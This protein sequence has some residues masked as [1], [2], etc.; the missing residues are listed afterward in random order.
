MFAILY[1]APD[2]SGQYPTIQEAVSAAHDGDEIQL[3]EGTFIGPG[4]WDVD[5]QGKDLSIYSRSH[6]AD[7]CI[8]EAYDVKGYRH[9]GFIFDQD[10]IVHI[11]QVGFSGSNDMLPFS[12]GVVCVEGTAKITLQDCAF[13]NA[14][15]TGAY[16]GGGEL[17]ILH[18]HF[19]G[20]YAAMNPGC[21]NGLGG[22][23]TIKD[24]SF[25][26]NGNDG[27]A[28]YIQNGYLK[29]CSFHNNSAYSWGGSLIAGGG[30]LAEDC[31]FS[32]FAAFNG[33]AVVA[34]GGSTFRR[35]SFY[36]EGAY[37]V[38]GIYASG[39][40]G[41]C[42]T[43]DSCTWDEI[44]TAGCVRIMENHLIPDPLESL[45]LDSQSWGKI[46]AAYR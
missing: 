24:S 28:A 44:E 38:E 34:F 35:C 2:G 13:I 22:F 40:P 45:S 4:N 5:F 8:V 9:Q 33:G 11:E 7:S 1:V 42:V 26:N 29:N 6:D 31:H 27:G 30:V 32:G 21:I 23:V 15:G 39:S 25:Q 36:A 43:L 37:P 17:N 18:Y 12:K 19:G 16:C 20:N 46:K 41:H 3:G 10:E 14:Q